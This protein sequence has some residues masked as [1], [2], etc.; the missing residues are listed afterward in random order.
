[1]RFRQD[2]LSIL[3]RTAISPYVMALLLAVWLAVFGNI[4]LWRSL[5]YVAA[6]VWKQNLWLG[7]FALLLVEISSLL[8]ILVA[9]PRLFKPLATLLLMTAGLA[10]YFMTTYGVVIDPGMA[11][12]VFDTDMAESLD[13]LSW[14]MIQ[15]VAIVS[16]PPIWF[17]WSRSVQWKPFFRQ[18]AY[19]LLAA[20][21]TLAIIVLTVLFFYQSLT[22]VMRSHPDFRYQINPASSVYSAAF[23]VHQRWFSA[24]REFHQVATDAH[25]GIDVDGL[26]SL[27]VLVVGE[28]ARADHFSLAGYSRQ[29]NPVMERWQA[30]QGLVYFSSVSSCGTST[31]SSLPCMFSPLG[32]RS[33]GDGHAGEYESVLDVLKR[34]GVSVLWLD[35]QS[36]CKGVCDRVQ[37]MKHKDLCDQD[38]C[39]D[40]I[41]LANMKSLYK[42]ASTE[43][44]PRKTLVVMH[45]MGSHGPAYY[46]RTT[47]EY[48]KFLPE[49]TSNVLSECDSQKVINAYDNTIFYTDFFLG[50]VL[51]YLKGLA[52][53][54][55]ASTAMLY[56]SDHGESLGENGIYL[57]GLPYSLAPSSQT[58]VPM[59]VWLSKQEV[60][61]SG[62]DLDCLKRHRDKPLSHDNIFHSLIGFMGVSTS[63]YQEDMDMFSSCHLGAK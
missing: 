56:V 50:Q 36:G 18:A 58:H 39:K 17:L 14:A 1:M 33:G 6:P 30:E 26:P 3:S 32:R 35:N 21:I 4:P 10:S 44:E 52:D 29:T 43:S 9:W 25:L 42:D 13:L 53:E 11:T 46:K 24:S 47:P 19:N 41:M 45:Q 61:Q 5:A 62:F 27:M 20:S 57:H 63:E 28:T 22:S 55:R 40:E 7:G 37:S 15:S 38:E 34:A 54:G 49:C 12:N 59:M 60:V 16:I 48:K 51:E 31:A 8:L 2:Y 23:V